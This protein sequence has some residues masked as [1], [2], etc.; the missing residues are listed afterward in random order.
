MVERD[1]QSAAIFLCAQPVETDS[2]KPLENVALLTV[3]WRA[4]MCIN[5]TLNLLESG[6]NPFLA[7]CPD[8]VFLRLDLDAKL[9]Q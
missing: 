6:D 7:G 2:V 9:G 3:L 4:V 1:Q 8:S 5:E